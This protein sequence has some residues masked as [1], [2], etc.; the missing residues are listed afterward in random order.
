MDE[1]Q[2]RELISLMENEESKYYFSCG[3]FSFNSPYGACPE[4]DG[5]GTKLE[6]DTDLVIPD[7]SLP[8]L[9]AIAPWRQT[10]NKKYFEKLV[11]GLATEMSFDPTTPFE[12]LNGRRTRYGESENHRKSKKVP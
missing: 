8:A 1:W 5:I 12:D 2:S 3:F 4:C 11:E 6:V 10:L 9:E 7:P